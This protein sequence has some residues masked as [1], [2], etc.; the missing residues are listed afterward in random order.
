M[1]IYVYILVNI[2]LLVVKKMKVFK[3]FLLGID[4]SYRKIKN[5]CIEIVCF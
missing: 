3:Y 5:Y 4:I 2:L 1:K